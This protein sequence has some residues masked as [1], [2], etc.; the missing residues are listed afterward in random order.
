MTS[1]TS[2]NYLQ[3]AARTVAQMKVALEQNLAATTELLGGL[4]IQSITI[5]GS[6]ITPAAGS[7][8]FLS[9]ATPGGAATA[10]LNTCVPTNIKNGSW[11]AMRAATSGQVVV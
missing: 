8:A 2:P 9:I 7:A 6:S 5:S 4:P 1:F 11:I 3:D 10:N